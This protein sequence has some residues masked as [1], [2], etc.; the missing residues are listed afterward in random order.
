MAD[1][2]SAAMTTHDRNARRAGVIAMRHYLR[3]ASE[4]QTG[5][6]ICAARV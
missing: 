2:L 4:R 5:I 1:G 6:P 3:D